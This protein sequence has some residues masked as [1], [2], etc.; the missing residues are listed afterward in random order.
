ME[1]GVPTDN[2]TLEEFVHQ[3]ELAKQERKRARNARR[4]SR[5]NNDEADSP[6]DSNSSPE[7]TKVEHLPSSMLLPSTTTI[8]SVVEPSVTEPVAPTLTFPLETGEPSTRELSYEPLGKHVQM[9]Q[10][11]AQ[12]NQK[13]FGSEIPQYTMLRETK[14]QVGCLM[15]LAIRVY[16]KEMS[17]RR[18]ERG[19]KL[20]RA[21][22][23]LEMLEIL[24]GLGIPSRNIAMH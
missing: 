22:L 23:A 7:L 24:K 19:T 8:G 5:Q 21:S 11:L 3:R 17:V 14:G 9:L 20:C 15:K 4:R 18:E 1:G 2:R 13:I 6:S 10:E 12:K 16:G